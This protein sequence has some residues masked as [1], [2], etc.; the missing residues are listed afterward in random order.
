MKIGELA[1]I[2]GVT[3]DTIRF[4]EQQGLLDSPP[5]TR[6]KYREFPPEALQRLTFIRRARE[7]GFRLEEISELLTL[8]AAQEAGSRDVRELTAAKLADVKARITKLDLIARSLE[9]LLC[10]CQGDSVTRAHCPIL[11]AF[12]QPQVGQG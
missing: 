1:R 3:I 5:R 12:S 7:L 10:Q 2:A 11:Q 9:D 4:Y 6:S 8:A